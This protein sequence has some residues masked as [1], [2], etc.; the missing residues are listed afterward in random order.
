MQIATTR[1]GDI[2]ISDQKVICFEEG[3]PGLETFRRFVLLS[4]EDTKPFHWLQSLDDPDVSLAVIN[5]YQ[6]FSD[7]KPMIAETVF[8]HLDI[9]ETEDVLVLTVA[10]IPQDFK[11][12]TANLLA[13]ILINTKNNTGQQVILEGGDYSLRQP[14]YNEIRKIVCEGGTSDAG[15]DPQA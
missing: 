13:P 2:T 1:F 9:E 4:T 15:V 8:T 6:L 7:Y 12:M 3:L 14:I 10:V 11:K 5:P